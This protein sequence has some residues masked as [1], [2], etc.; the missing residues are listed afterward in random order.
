M[1]QRRVFIVHA[2]EETELALELKKFVE[3]S[4][5]KKVVVSLTGHFDIKGQKWL[6][7]V[8]REIQQCAALIVLCSPGS[9]RQ[10]SLFFKAGLGMARD[11]PV[12]P[13]CHSGVLPAQLPVPLNLLSD[14]VL[15][16]IPGM[17]A[18]Y[19]LLA[20]ALSCGEPQLDFTAF[21]ERV[22]LFELTHAFWEGINLAY[23]KLPE[24]DSNLAMALERDEPYMLQISEDEQRG[25]EA[26]FGL[27]LYNQTI[28]VRIDES[29]PYETVRYI[30]SRG[31][32]YSKITGDP[33]FNGPRRSA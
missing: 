30:V 14:A 27:L 1:D 32:N 10:S 7:E 11:I 24:F 3:R 17:K 6:D 21:I 15:T 8:C 20:K 31:E 16:D 4:F 19:P 2:S 26:A 28:L 33:N 13:L 22:R 12:I 29:A 23:S 9:V 5:L 18:I 25:F